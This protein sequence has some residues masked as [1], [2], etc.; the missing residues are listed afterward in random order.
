MIYF[1]SSVGGAAVVV[2]AP[3]RP[4]MPSVM[5]ITHN[6]DSDE[7]HDNGDGG[8]ADDIKATFR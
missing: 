6:Y 8:D 2:V 1:S 7:K 5:M 3:N 4:A